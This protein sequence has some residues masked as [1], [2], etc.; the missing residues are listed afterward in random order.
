MQFDK[1]KSLRE[2]WGNKPCD[3]ASFEKEYYLGTDTSD[4]VCST[5]GETFTRQE[6]QE[7]EEVKM[8]RAK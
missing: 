2:E 4:Y 7:I 1:A 3:H 8:K 6:K 5:C